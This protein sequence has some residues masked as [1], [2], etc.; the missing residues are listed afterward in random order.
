MATEISRNTVPLREL[1]HSGNMIYIIDVIKVKKIERIEDLSLDVF[2]QPCE[3]P[4]LCACF[5]FPLKHMEQI[6]KHLCGPFLTDLH[7]LSGDGG[8]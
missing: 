6:N 8:Y 1:T 5:Q 2:R 3:S 4:F 7:T